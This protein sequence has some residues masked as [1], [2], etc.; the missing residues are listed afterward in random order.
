M[1]RRL[2][3]KLF[4][5]TPASK[6][7]QRPA[8]L[9]ID[10]DAA[11]APRAAS[12]V[13]KVSSQNLM[14]VCDAYWTALGQPRT[15]TLAESLS[16][17][18]EN[19]KYNVYVEAITELSTRGPEILEWAGARLKHP[20]YDAREQAAFL[21][22]ELGARAQLGERRDA[23]VKALCNL[24]VRPKVEDG[25]E[26]QANAAALMALGKI[27]D[28]RIISVAKRLLTDPE[29]DDDEIQWE[30]A[31]VLGEITGESFGGEEDPVEA[32]RQWLHDHSA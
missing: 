21:L 8:R 6:P 22:G 17:E 2:W 9:P 11:R 31:N 15:G 32:A 28:R 20:E 23:V 30:A 7:R 27:G 24:A 1:F 19:R 13:Q 10:A 18:K 29:W 3:Q 14:A 4:G 5:E 16:S 26:L 12:S 25:K